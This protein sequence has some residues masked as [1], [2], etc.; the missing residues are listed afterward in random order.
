MNYNRP[1]RFY[2]GV[3]LHARTLFTRAPNDRGTTAIEPD[4]PAPSGE[5]HAD[6]GHPGDRV[7]MTIP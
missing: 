2:C 5:L 3:D 6:L 7:R 1:H 4:R